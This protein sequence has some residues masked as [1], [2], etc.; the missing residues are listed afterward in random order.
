MQNSWK[1]CA[2]NSILVPTTQKQEIARL[3]NEFV[4]KLVTV[5]EAG[6]RGRADPQLLFDYRCYLQDS[7]KGVLGTDYPPD[8][9]KCL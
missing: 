2:F 3:S 8:I 5:H 7:N 4:N 1:N 9:K 6:G